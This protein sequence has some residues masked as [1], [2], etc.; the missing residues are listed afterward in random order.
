MVFEDGKI[1]INRKELAILSSGMKYRI[2]RKILTELLGNIQGIE[3]IHVSDISKLIDNNIKGKQYIIG[4][5]FTVKIK[6]KNIIEF[7]KNK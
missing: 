3:K 1:T 4:N 7:S 6:T 5:K 2:I